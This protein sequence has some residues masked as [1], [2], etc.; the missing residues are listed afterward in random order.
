MITAIGFSDLL[1]IQ[2]NVPDSDA[3]GFF[4][5]LDFKNTAE[6]IESAHYYLSETRDEDDDMDDQND[7]YKSWLDYSTF[8]AIIDN[9]LAHHPDATKED[10]LD[11]V[12]YYLEQDDFLD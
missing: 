2:K 7:K 8:L 1:K 10:L 11:A 12:I 9:K 4:V 5:D 3:M 6:C